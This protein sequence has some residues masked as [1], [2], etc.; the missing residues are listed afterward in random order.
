M[1]IR[2][3]VNLILKVP[4]VATQSRAGK[5]VVYK[6]Q[7]VLSGI[8]VDQT[9]EQSNAQVKG[10]GGA[11]GLTENPSAFQSWM[12]A[13]PEVVWIL[14]EFEE[15]FTLLHCKADLHH[16]EQMPATQKAFAEEVKSLVSTNND[17][18]N[19]YMEQSQIC[20]YL[21]SRRSC[22]I[23]WY[24]QQRILKLLERRSTKYLSRRDF[25]HQ[26]NQWMT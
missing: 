12:V 15:N 18:G 6:S 14:C 24:L 23:I 9:Q 17:M 1:H 7:K 8:A 25:L 21:I 16:H 20:W 19:P 3:L 13:G 26:A 11:I 2:D 5:W 22:Q 10:S 4:D